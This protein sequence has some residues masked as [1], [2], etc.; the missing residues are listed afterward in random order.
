M[1]DGDYEFYNNNLVDSSNFKL[2][3]QHGF[4]FNIGLVPQA[5]CRPSVAALLT[6]TNPHTNNV[7]NNSSPGYLP[8]S[9][10]IV[11]ILKDNGYSTFAG[12]KWWENFS[13]NA[14]L[15]FNYYGI[16]V[17]EGVRPTNNFIRVGNQQGLMT[18]LDTHLNMPK[19]IW[20][21]PLI[22][23][24]P[25]DP[26]AEF[27]AMIDDSSITPYPWL[28]P[29]DIPPDA[30]DFVSDEANFMAMHNWINSA[31]GDFVHKLDVIGELDNT[32]FVFYNDNGLCN[33]YISKQSPYDHGIR[34]YVTFSWRANQNILTN[35]ANSTNIIEVAD[36]FPTVMDLIGVNYTH[37]TDGYSVKNMLYGLPQNERTSSHGACYSISP[38]A[39]DNESFYE[40]TLAVY[41]RTLQYKYI[42]FLKPVRAN[43]VGD[44]SPVRWKHRFLPVPTRNRG[45]EELYDLTTDTNERINLINNPDLQSIK[46]QLKI[47]T[48]DWWYNESDGVNT[49]PTDFNYDNIT[50]LYD[51]SQILSM[52]GTQITDKH[53]LNHN[54]IVDLSDLSA[55]LTS[56]GLP[57]NRP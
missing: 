18:F 29:A 14:Q 4:T 20:W 7:R 1:D 36:I 17:T 25:F 42:Y 52:F 34:T 40:S 9:N 19:F 37:Q 30:T 44:S 10:T 23:H 43:E 56:F 24:L 39:G 12:G 33:G 11:R 28:N 54:G 46:N 31:F 2:L 13:S 6:G 5:T 51:L 47:E 32:L 38:I 3:A 45:D 35:T 41:T 21:A 53:D 55:V 26:P 16:D 8:A 48:F 15:T 49:C 22:P 57:C 50:D 27:R